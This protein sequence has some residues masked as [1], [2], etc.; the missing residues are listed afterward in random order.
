MISAIVARLANPKINLAAYGG[1]VL[2]ISLIIEAPII[3]LLAASTAM[4]KDWESYK[5][6]RSFM[7]YTS[8]FLTAIHALIA[9]TPLYYVLVENIIGVPPEVVE[10]ARVGMMIM[11][12]WTWAIGFR[13][14]QQ[15]V[16]IRFGQ[17]DGVMWCTVVRLTTLTAILIA[18][19]LVGS[20]PGMIVAT[21][22]QALGVTFEAIYAG[23]RVRPVLRDHL[24]S[25]PPAE[26]FSWRAFAAFYTPLMMTSVLQFIG[27]PIGS[28]ALSRMPQA[29][30]SL[31]TWSVLSYFSF[32]LRSVGIAYNE[33]VIAL[34]DEPGS[35]FNLRKFANTLAW[36]STVVIIIFAATPLS[37]L[38][39]EK[40]TGLASPLARM[41]QNALWFFLL[42]PA[43]G[44]FQSWFQGSLLHGRK[45]RAITES[46]VIF[47]LTLSAILTA[48]VVWGQITGLYVGTFAFAFAILTQII[49]QWYRSR[50]VR[51]QVKNRDEEFLAIQN[52]PISQV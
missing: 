34:L 10:P 7:L 42:M 13:R 43:L 23:L 37:L 38:W 22:A 44:V 27:Q 46:V 30:D 19:Y 29:L 52:P 47:L 49:W 6:M 33:V 48:G 9:F 5:K 51:E 35:F 16:M 39:F 26:P 24:R 1:I 17:S 11:L 15:G 32:L 20:I 8:A 25:A 21:T 36:I 31:A 28:A 41:T 12:P 40:V 14:F 2:P 3:M 18:G 4:S 50:R 45:T